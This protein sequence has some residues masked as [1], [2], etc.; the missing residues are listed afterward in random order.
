MALIGIGVT[1]KEDVQ[2]FN[3]GMA[4]YNMIIAVIASLYVE[5][6]GRRTLFLVSN[7]G[8]LFGYVLWT[9]GAGVHANTG[10][11][12]AANL[13]MAAIF[14]YGVSSSPSRCVD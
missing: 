6:I 11:R 10:D 13:V 9:I 5:K 4:I 8:M 1:N 3:L 12:N 14:M 7:A 2:I